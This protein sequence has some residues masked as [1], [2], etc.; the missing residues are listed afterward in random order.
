MNNSALTIRVGPNGR[1]G[2]VMHLTGQLN[3]TTYPQLLQAAQT[4]YQ[5]NQR[6]LTL[7]LADLQK[8]T[9]AGLFAL[10]SV[11]AI[12]RNEK[13]LAPEAGW[14]AI[15][16]MKNDLDGLPQPWLKLAN[17]Q[18]QV[19][20]QLHQAGFANFVEIYEDVATE[21]AVH[22]LPAAE[23]PLEK[24]QDQPA[25]QV[26]HHRKKPAGYL[27]KALNLLGVMPKA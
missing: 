11:V 5:Q 4:I 26:I 16:T 1:S 2:S 15:R 21:T 6:H 13:P 3:G 14:S 25:A 17:P 20:H 7:D 8:I 22:T 23:Q 19:L 27:V 24:E 9:L 18:P 10:H 12:L